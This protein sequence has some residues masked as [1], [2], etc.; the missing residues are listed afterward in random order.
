M[1]R[2]IPFLLF[3]ASLMLNASSMGNI[4]SALPRAQDQKSHGYLTEKGHLTHKLQVKQVQGGFAGDT[5]W[6]WTVEPNGQ[7]KKFSVFNE[8]L[9][10]KAQ[11]T[12][13]KK[14]R[15]A[16]ANQLAKYNLLKLPAMTGKPT[17]NRQLLTVQF[18]K[19]TSQ[20][21]FGAGA[22]IPKGN[23]TTVDGRFGGIYHSIASMT[24][25]KKGAP[26]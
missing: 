2:H 9:T 20:L 23:P 17:V 10:L 16:L 25:G 15:K 26:K 18:G 13:D 21:I 14:Q 5:G 3:A 11:G 24:N 22:L 1:L 4:P 7:W 19:K 12:F 6:L 8:K